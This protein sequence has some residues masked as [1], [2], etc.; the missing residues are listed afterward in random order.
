MAKAQTRLR[1]LEQP[2]LNPLRLDRL[3]KLRI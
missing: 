3:D 1:K 2:C